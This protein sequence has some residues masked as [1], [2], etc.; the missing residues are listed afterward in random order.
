MVSA[1]DCTAQGKLL[2]LGPI[3]VQRLPQRLVQYKIEH[4]CPD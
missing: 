4:L 2:R 1:M 3:V